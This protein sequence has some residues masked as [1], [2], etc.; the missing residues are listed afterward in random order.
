[1]GYCR[2]LTRVVI[3]LFFSIF[4]FLLFSFIYNKI[5]LVPTESESNELERFYGTLIKI[6]SAKDIIAL[7]NYTIEHVV[8]YPNGVGEINI[9]H[10]LKTKKGFCFHRS[11]LMQKVLILNDIKVRP[12]FLYSNPQASSTSIFDFFSNRIRTHNVF[13]YFWQGRW[14]VME[15]NSEMH[16]IITLNE[17]L[18]QQKIF[19]NRPNYIRYLNNR[20]GRFIGPSW[21]PDVY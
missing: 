11:L 14:Y 13:E 9:K 5:R 8:H 15:T 7:Q 16:R 2:N 4:L 12:V 19:E 20:N 21:L 6:K 10:I 17:Y 18:L 1:M 3:I